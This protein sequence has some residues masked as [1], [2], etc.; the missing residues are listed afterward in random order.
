MGQ[1]NEKSVQ[2]HKPRT[3][4]L[5]AASGTIIP[6]E[7]FKALLRIVVSEILCEP[8]RWDRI[9]NSFSEKM[10]PQKHFGECRIFP[11]PSDYSHLLHAKLSQST[12]MN[13]VTDE[14][15]NSALSSPASSRPKGKYEH[16]KIAIIGSSGRFPD[17][18]SHE[19]FWGL[20]LAGR[21]VHRKIPED[22][23][24]WRAHFDATGKKK[25]TSR[26][27]F[28]C[29]INEPGFFDA[30]FF[31]MSPRETKNT[32]PAARLAIMSTY[33]AFEMAG[34][35]VDRTPSTRHDRI[36]VFFGTANDDWRE[37][38]SNQDIDTY[39]IPGGNRAFV[40]GRIR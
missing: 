32:D 16:S 11:L 17:S 4:L 31:N 15:L 7:D 22:R 5:S 2:F 23:Y 36:G 38:H 25:N 29:F 14:F 6:A 33:E 27:P 20:L 24:D 37:A 13:V 12:K 28:G 19:D 8:I 40:P 26:V 39:Y 18:A 30:G 3:A 10:F 9:L 35:V 21:D 34:L 1:L